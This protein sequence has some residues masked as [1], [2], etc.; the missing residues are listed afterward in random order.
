MGMA[1]MRGRLADA[2]R[3]SHIGDVE[4]ILKEYAVQDSPDYIDK[5]RDKRLKDAERLARNV[6]RKN[7][8]I[9]TAIQKARAARAN[10]KK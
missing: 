8:K 9:I 6:Q 10:K 5:I 2:V 1:K 7:H 3:A 4:E